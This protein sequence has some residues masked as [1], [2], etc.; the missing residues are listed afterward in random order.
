MKP[1]VSPAYSPDL[2]S[3]FGLT[4]FGNILCPLLRHLIF[5]AE[6]NVG[7]VSGFL[8]GVAGVLGSA[9]AR[10]TCRKLLPLLPTCGNIH[11]PDRT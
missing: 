4:S 3:L 5:A 11:I 1:M 9:R 7:N 10:E 8:N 6:R 2:R